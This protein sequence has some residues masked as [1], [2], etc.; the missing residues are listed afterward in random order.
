M[1]SSVRVD[2]GEGHGGSVRRGRDVGQP[3]PARRRCG[4]GA[5]C[6]RGRTR[7]CRSRPAHPPRPSRAAGRRSGRASPAASGWRPLPWRPRRVGRATCRS[8]CQPRPTY[9]APMGTTHRRAHA[10]VASR[11]AV[12]GGTG[13]GSHHRRGPD[14]PTFRRTPDGVIWRGIRTPEGTDHAA[15]HADPRPRHRH[16]RGLGDGAEW[17][18]DRLPRMLGADDDPTGFEPLHKPIADA[19]RR[20]TATGGW[21]RPTW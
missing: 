13:A 15:H 5:A 12:P 6:R 17:V 7:R 3:A 4:A 18:L 21:A 14:D 16:R 1:S 8:S 9:S 19:W 10:R 11:L 20:D 2:L